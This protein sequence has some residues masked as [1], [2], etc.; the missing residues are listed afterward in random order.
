MD[1]VMDRGKLIRAAQIG[2]IRAGHGCAYPGC[3]AI[4]SGSQYCSDHQAIHNVGDQERLSASARGYD[5]R[6]RK[7][8]LMYLR[9]HPLCEDIY[10][11]HTNG[12]V[13]SSEVD[14]IVPKRNGGTDDEENLQALC[15][16]CHSKKTGRG[17]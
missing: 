6:W 5:R 2:A 17:G 7:I 10:G 15:H 3:P 14:H 9:A 1:S 13:A 16:V 12:P 8:R 4:I 11:L